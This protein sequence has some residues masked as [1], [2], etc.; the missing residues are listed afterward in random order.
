[1]DNIILSQMHSHLH[2]SCPLHSSKHLTP[3]PTLFH[4]AFHK[5]CGSHT[6]RSRISIL[7]YTHIYAL[8]R[9]I[10]PICSSL[11]HTHSH[12]LTDGD[13]IIATCSTQQQPIIGEPFIGYVEMPEVRRYLRNGNELKKCD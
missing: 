11:S 2:P 5:D 1:M 13:Y 3:S 10:N 12:S 9:N 7:I 8:S 6:Q 4:V